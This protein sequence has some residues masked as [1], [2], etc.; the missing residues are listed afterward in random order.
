MLVTMLVTFVK[1]MTAKVG[2]LF[3]E[4]PADT[5]VTTSG[6]CQNSPSQTAHVPRFKRL[7]AACS[8]ASSPSNVWVRAIV[9]VS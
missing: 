5:A 1:R 6:P 7:P 4:V 9:K 8:S 3:G 2:R